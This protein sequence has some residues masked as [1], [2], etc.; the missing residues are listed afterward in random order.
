MFHGQARWLGLDASTGQPFVVVASIISVCHDITGRFNSRC[1]TGQLLGLVGSNTTVCCAKHVT[2][3][4]GSLRR[5]RKRQKQLRNGRSAAAVDERLPLLARK[6]AGLLGVS[7]EAFGDALAAYVHDN[8]DGLLRP[9]VTLIVMTVRRTSHQLHEHDSGTWI[10]LER[11]SSAVFLV[12]GLVA[13]AL[14]LLM[15][16]GYYRRTVGRSVPQGIVHAARSCS[17]LRL[18][19][20]LLVSCSQLPFQESWAPDLVPLR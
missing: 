8:P 15:R 18:L 9:Q 14:Y 19:V 10:Y 7:S 1:A 11:C 13:C 3:R 2:Y 17:R 6:P 4:C 5:L 12:R 20:S 16:E